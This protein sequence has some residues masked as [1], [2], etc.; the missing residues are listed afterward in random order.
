MHW[1]NLFV[2]VTVCFKSIVLLWHILLFM[3]AQTIH[4]I[5]QVLL[6]R[7]W[8]GVLWVSLEVWLIKVVEILKSK[9]TTDLH[10]LRLLSDLPLLHDEETL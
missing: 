10:F 8:I 4:S 1:V 7:I 3:Q 9:A 5:T 6:A 2:C